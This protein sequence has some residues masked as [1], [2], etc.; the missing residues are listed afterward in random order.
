MRISRTNDVKTRYINTTAV[1]VSEIFKVVLFINPSSP[2]SSHTFQ[3]IASLFLLNY[4]RSESI[5]KTI[6]YVNEAAV[7]NYMNTLMLAVPAGLY[8]FQNNLLFVALSNL[9]AAT[10]QITYQL[11]ILTT[12]LFS[13]LMLSK[14]LDRAKWFSLV[15]LTVGVAFVQ[16]PSSDSSA[17]P[18]GDPYIGLIAVLIACFSS[19]FAGVYFEKILTNSSGSLWLRNIQLGFFG[20]VLGLIGVYLNDW[21][22][23]HEGGF[24]QGYDSLTWTVVVL[25]GVGG[26]IIA[27]VI[28]YADNILK[29]FAA[30]L[31]IIISA[32]VSG[33]FFH[34]FV[35]TLNFAIGAS[36]VIAATFIY[37]MPSAP[38]PASKT[39]G[40]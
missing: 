3:M 2:T 6:H 38:P 13:V 14:A 4:E 16:M 36:L 5:L 37:G 12:A 18:V 24:L 27:A 9:D 15:L 30:S 17:R 8:T 34:D 20:T 29:S 1:V 10:Y 40:V 25:Q 11:K 21:E 33:F 31:S 23:V 22:K 32:V 7:I 19:G 28:K 39:S 35:L 26:L